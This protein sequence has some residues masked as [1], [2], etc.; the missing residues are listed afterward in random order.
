MN[1]RENFYR[2]SHLKSIF[3]PYIQLINSSRF[4]FHYSARIFSRFSQLEL[5]NIVKLF[6]CA[7]FM[8]LKG[9]Q[10]S[11]SCTLVHIQMFLAVPQKINIKT[12]G[13]YNFAPA[14][15]LSLA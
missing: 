6:T 15:L 5:I 3:H 1:N 11:L 12:S 14:A 13:K 8:C 4:V 10:H 7:R 2:Y 9:G